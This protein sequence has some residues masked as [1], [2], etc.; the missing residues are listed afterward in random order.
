VIFLN[1]LNPETSVFCVG[2]SIA[3]D[4]LQSLVYQR[5]E[6]IKALI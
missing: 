5:Y 1:S 3:I 6:T 2:I 4:T